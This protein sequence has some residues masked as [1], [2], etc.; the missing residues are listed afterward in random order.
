MNILIFG[1]SITQGYDDTEKGGWVN[2][3]FLEYGACPNRWETGNYH[4]IFNLGVSGDTTRGLLKRFELEL[5]ARVADENLIIF[6]I[7]GNDAVVNNETGECAIPMKEFTANY[8]TLLTTAKQYGRVVCLGLTD[9]DYSKLDP[10]PWYAG[11]SIRSIDIERY[12]NEIQQLA[13]KAD[14]LHIPLQGLFSEDLD[15]Y[16]Y[17]GDHPSA[18]GHQRIYERVKNSLEK[19]GL[20]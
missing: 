13:E 4:I 7:G 8:Q 19:K 3:F 11:H 20:L 18:A 10:M 9:S 15:T 17:D 6:D 16:L 1:T 2:R 12:D 14:V 5:Q